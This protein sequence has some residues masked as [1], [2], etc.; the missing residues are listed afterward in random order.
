M[1]IVNLQKTPYD[2]EAD[3]KIYS[4]T[5]EFMKLLLTEL[6]LYKLFEENFY[7]N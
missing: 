2:H 6:D 5:D 3:V 7:N 1:V 4:K